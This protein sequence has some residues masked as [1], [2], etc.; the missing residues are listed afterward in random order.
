MMG[1]N[2][3]I[4]HH[5]KDHDNPMN[6]KVSPGTSRDHAKGKQKHARSWMSER[7]GSQNDPTGK[8]EV[9]KDASGRKGSQND[10]T[11]KKEV[12]KDASGRKGSQNDQTGKKEVRKDASGKKETLNDPTG[13]KEARKDASGKNGQ[14]SEILN[15]SSEIES[16]IETIEEGRYGSLEEYSVSERSLIFQSELI[17]Q[18][19]LANEYRDS[20]Q[21][22]AADFDNYRKRIEREREKLIAFANE[23][24]ILKLLVVLDNLD[25]AVDN[26]TSNEEDKRDSFDSFYEGIRL[27]QSQFRKIMADEGLKAID[28]TGVAFDPYKHEA[29][30]HI[31]NNNLENNTV[32]DVLLKGYYLKDKM[33]RPAQVRISKK[34][35]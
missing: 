26:D 24:L 13:K 11:G 34:E 15:S 25:R 4:A 16:E 35:E 2:D 30:M 17:S 8:K 20:L 7:K 14:F 32:T 28:E 29:M 10:P 19:K 3:L 6:E 31:V 9:R 21:R 5:K 33:I 27:I 1:E 22:M 18:I 23:G 12:R